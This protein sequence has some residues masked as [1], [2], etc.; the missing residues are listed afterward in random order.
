MVEKAW[1][2]CGTETLG[3]TLDDTVRTPY[4]GKIPI[5]PVMDS[6]FDQIVIRAILNP[7][8]TQVLKMLDTRISRYK[9]EEWFDTYLVVFLLLN[10]IELSTAHDHKFAKL[11]GHVVGYHS[12]LLPISPYFFH[13]I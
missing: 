13:T 10:N 11:H 4:A 9:R 8:R 12:V 7:L 3:L 6:Q 2:I 1:R 5:P